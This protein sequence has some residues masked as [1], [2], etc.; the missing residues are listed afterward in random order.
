MTA[1]Q[2]YRPAMAIFFAL[3]LVMAVI[4]GGVVVTGG[5]PVRPEFYGPIVYAVPALA[6]VS[7]QV[8]LSGMAIV[9]CAWGLPRMAAIGAFGM[10]G[11][12][13]FFAA[14]AVV[15][16]ASGTLLVAMAIPAGA[17]S[18]LCAIVCYRGRDG[19]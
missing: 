19:Q 7:L 13:E 11:L 15:A 4:F 9:G 17:A 3:P 2:R 10:S 5:T 1:F 14:A 6:W 8:G 12:F 16:G 18:M